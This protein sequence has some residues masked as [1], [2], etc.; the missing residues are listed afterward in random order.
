M[1]ESRFRRLTGPATVPNR[2][3]VRFGSAA[4]LR[5]EERAS[6]GTANVHLCHATIA[7][8]DLLLDWRRQSAAPSHVSPPATA[9]IRSVIGAHGERAVRHN[10]PL[11]GGRG[12]LDRAGAEGT[13]Q[14]ADAG[15]DAAAVWGFRGL[16]PHL[17]GGLDDCCSTHGDCSMSGSRVQRF[18]PIPTWS[19]GPLVG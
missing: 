19:L 13:V 4:S 17:R 11:G 14:P 2:G 8:G 9:R 18:A 16:T 15:P 10:R 6:S 12:P 5:Q 3:R 7:E 1:G